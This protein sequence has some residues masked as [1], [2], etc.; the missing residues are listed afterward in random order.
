MKGSGKYIVNEGIKASP[1]GDSR[2]H[3]LWRHLRKRLPDQGR[4]VYG[5]MLR[6]AS[7]GLGS[8]AVSVLV[9]WW[10]SRH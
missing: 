5:Q 2:R 3:R 7:Y 6:G 9:M 4:I 8:S 10:Q 1:G